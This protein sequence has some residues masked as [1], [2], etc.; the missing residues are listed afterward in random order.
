MSNGNSARAVPGRATWMART[1]AITL[2]IALATGCGGGGSGAAP[3]AGP[4]DGSGTGTPAATPPVAPSSTP[5]SSSPPTNPGAGSG[6]P[7]ADW[8]KPTGAVIKANPSNYLTLLRAL[9]PGET[10][11]LEAGVYDDPNDVPGLPIFELAG[12]ETQ[13]ILIT[14]PESGPRPKFLGRS[15]HNTVRIRNSSWVII[16]NLEIDS[17]NLG[18]SGVAAQGSNH[19]IWLENLYIHGVGRDQQNVGI[20]TVSAPNWNWVIRGNTIVGAG[21]GMYLG[22]SDG[23]NA[24]VAGTI[25]NN[26]VRDTIGY[27]LQ[28][29]HQNPRPAI[30]GMPTGKSVTVIRHNVF[31]KG[32]NSSTGGMARPNVLVGHFPKS[33]PG[34]DDH[35]E[36][37]GN[38]FWQ[39]P[40]EALFQ[41]EGNIA[42][43]SNVM[44]TD[45]GA[46]INIQPHHDVPKAIEIFGNTIIAKG[47]GIRVT[48]GAS[49][50]EQRVRGNAV[51][52]DSPISGGT[53][54]GNFTGAY[55]HAAN[56]LVEPF[57]ALGS[58]QA[59]P[60]AGALSG[61]ALDT[62]GLTNYTDWDVDFNRQARDW[63]IRGAYSGGGTNPG[64]TPVLEAR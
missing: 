16:R 12:T 15:T 10:L 27:N 58:F 21:T 24:F 43:Y 14:G 8:P 37:Y 47:S 6:L 19:H 55:A 60:L 7:S 45:S 32:A 28:I 53:Q 62:T 59:F 54:A 44:A 5:P 17:R 29:K 52:S 51:F 50:H 23:E 18:G 9:K 56:H 48:G 46:A 35:Y 41:G 22:N 13:P 26:L 36:I 57:G 11:E 61:V 31:T 20:S 49:G 25:E 40:T 2:A 39:N 30:A 42:M 3:L 1:A 34:V 63:T 64:W 33:G 38:F 4:G